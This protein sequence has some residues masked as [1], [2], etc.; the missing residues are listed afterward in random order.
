M[1]FPVRLLPSF[2]HLTVLMIVSKR[3]SYNKDPLLQRIR[4][5]QEYDFKRSQ[6]ER[7]LVSLFVVQSSCLGPFCEFNLLVMI[8]YQ[9]VSVSVSRCQYLSVCVST[10][11]HMSARVSTCQYMSVLVSTCRYVSLGVSKGQQGSVSVSSFQYVL[12]CVRTCQ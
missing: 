5:C 9:Y 10:C 8:G 3:L 6:H 11:Q 7:F 1:H 2:G 4:F 12:G